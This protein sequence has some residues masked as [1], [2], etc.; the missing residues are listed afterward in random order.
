MTES[1]YMRPRINPLLKWYL[2][3]VIDSL[4]QTNCTVPMGFIRYWDASG[5]MH[6]LQIVNGDWLETRAAQ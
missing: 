3:G 2:R 4:R 5:I 1:L 6:E